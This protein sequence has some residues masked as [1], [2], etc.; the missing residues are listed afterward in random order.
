VRFGKLESRTKLDRSPASLSDEMRNP[1][2]LVKVSDRGETRQALLVASNE[3]AVRLSNG[4][5]LTYESGGKAV[6]TFRSHVRLRDAAGEREGRLVVN[7]PLA[8]GS[9]QLYQAD[10]RADDPDYSGLDA[11]RDP[12][13]SWVFTGFVLL[14]LGVVYM[15][16]VQP[17]LRRREA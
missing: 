5:V 14:V 17:R 2:V 13:V 1:A 15:I 7:A 3:D 9:W 12:G 10:F 6:K 11:V 16:Y 4:Y 8:L